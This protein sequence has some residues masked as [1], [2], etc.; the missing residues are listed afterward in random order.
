MNLSVSASKECDDVVGRFAIV[1]ASSKGEKIYLGI[2]GWQDKQ[3]WFDILKF[4][5]PIPFQTDGATKVLNFK[6]DAYKGAQAAYKPQA[7]KSSSKKNFMAV[8]MLICVVMVVAS[9]AAFNSDFFSASK[10]NSHLSA[11]TLDVGQSTLKKKF[12]SDAKQS[13][14]IEKKAA[15]EN[16]KINNGTNVSAPKKLE[17]KVPGKTQSLSALNKNDNMLNKLNGNISKTQ[18]TI[19]IVS[20]SAMTPPCTDELRFRGICK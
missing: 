12:F 7:K 13:E 10:N 6:K 2:N 20:E 5:K 4:N 19:E 17:Q 8:S 3:V 1:R 15:S 16:F 18:E 9:V 14:K 11:Q